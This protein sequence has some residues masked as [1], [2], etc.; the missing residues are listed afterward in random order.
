VRVLLTG[1]PVYS[2]LVPMLVPIAR[3]L[4]AAGH[5]VTVAT[6]TAMAGELARHDL[7]C[8]PL[9]G[10]L[11]GHQFRADPELASAIGLSAD[12]VPLPELDQ[13]PPG[14]GFG[15]LFA[16]V[17]TVR[18]ARDLHAVG[19][20][21]RPDLIVRECS[22]FAGFLVAE[23][24]GVPCVTLDISP[25]APSRHPGLLPTLNETRDTLG[26]PPLPD[27]TA[28][29]RHPWI[30]W[31]PTSWWPDGLRSPAHRHYR[32]PDMSAAAPLDP[33]IAALP[34][35]RPLVLATLGSNTGFML[36]GQDTPLARI[37][38]ALGDLPCTAVVALGAGIDPARW[39]GPQPDNVHL[40]SFVQQRL[41]LPACD[42]FITHA[43]F[44]A[45]S[46]ALA[47]GVPMV[48]LPLYAD[49]PTNAA[50]LAELH[51]GVTVPSESDQTSLAAAA[52]RVLDD[53]SFRYAARG[54]QRQILSLPGVD[55]LVADLADLATQ[56]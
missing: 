36:A 16:G 39:P 50:R 33:V 15:R 42:L 55:R 35:D 9:S 14:T 41:L 20:E 23:Q 48:A 34:A 54:F 8:R 6:G 2:H 7:P 1:A 28:L 51:V 25:L 13:M 18:N 43:G 11:V 21:L 26:L 44:G 38:A 56:A 52:R 47:A 53:P 45:V 32:A 3:A 10:M 27:V 5:E 17:S 24:L 37:V 46:E 19:E 29:S 4:R 40:V 30:G 49:Q 12:G 22:E 31:L